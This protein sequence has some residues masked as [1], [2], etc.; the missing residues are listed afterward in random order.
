MAAVALIAL[1]ALLFLPQPRALLDPGMTA[2]MLRCPP[3]AT[4]VDCALRGMPIGRATFNVPDTLPLDSLRP[5]TISVSLDEP[6][7]SQRA[8]VEAIVGDTGALI[9]TV[10]V[11]FAQRM[12]AMLIATEGVEVTSDGQSETRAVSRESGATWRWS[13]RARK[14]G[15]HFTMLNVAAVLLVDGAETP[16]VTHG[17]SKQVIVTRTIGQRVA[18]M[19]D[20]ASEHWAP[21]AGVFGAL[22]V[23]IKAGPKAYAMIRKKWISPPPGT[24]P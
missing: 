3:H 1:V 2:M 24:K 18:G 13:L 10:R 14:P 12:T 7:D 22:I 4:S 23:V 20:Y 9:D 8:L 16:H 11:R 5:M 21:L 15:R 17:F 19:L 6:A